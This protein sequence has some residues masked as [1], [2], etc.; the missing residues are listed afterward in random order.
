MAQSAIHNSLPVLLELITLLETHEEEYLK[1]EVEKRRTRLGAPGP[2]QLEKDIGKEVWGT[3]RVRAIHPIAYESV[4]HPYLQ[5]PWLYNEVLIHPNT[6]DNLR[7]HTEA[8][9]LR[10]KRRY[11]HTLPCTGEYATVKWNVSRELDELVNGAVLLR[12]PDELAWVTFLEGQDCE[13][14]G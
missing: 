13:N 5:L 6:E 8:T 9:L 7:R 14:I 4:D 1:K 2:E 3:S 10:Y 12:V 11:L